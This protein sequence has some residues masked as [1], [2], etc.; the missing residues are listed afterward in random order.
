MAER[1]PGS[2]LGVQDM[3]RRKLLTRLLKKDGIDLPARRPLAEIMSGEGALSFSQERFWFLD[4]LYPASAV[5]HI[6]RAWRLKGRIDRH[7]LG[8]G[9]NAIVRRHEILRTAFPSVNEKPVATVTPELLIPL[10]VI[11]LRGLS[12]QQHSAETSRAL[13]ADAAAPFDLARGP[14]IRAKLIQVADTDH[15]LLVVLHQI[16]CDGWSMSLFL[17]ELE[18][19]YRA[20]VTSRKFDLPELPIHYGTYAYRQRQLFQSNVLQSQLTYWKER[21]C[22][23]A[24][25]GIALP[26]DRR[27]PNVQSF[28]GAR[29]PLA[30]PKALVRGLKKLSAEEGT[31]L[32]MTLM[33]AF[34]VLLW[35]YSSQDDIRV[36][37]PAANRSQTGTE[38]L[39]GPFVNTLVLRTDLSGSPTFREL[40][41]R[42][43]MHCNGA[44]AHQDLPFDQLVEELRLERDLGRNPLFDVMLAYQNYPTAELKL[45]GLQVEAL[46][47]AGSTAKFDLTLS[48]A[49]RDAELRGFFE[50]STDLFDRPTIARMARHLLTLLRRIAAHPEELIGDVALL[51]KREREQ[52]LVRWNRTTAIYPKDRCIHELF[53]AQAA[54]TPRATAV[55]CAGQTLTYRELNCRANQLA[56][57]LRKL[58][59]GAESR[60]GICVERSLEMVVGLL[61][62]LKAGGA[63]V[64]LDP[65]YP[66]ARTAFMLKDAGVEVLLTHKKLSTTRRL[67]AVSVQSLGRRP[68]VVCIDAEWTKIAREDSRQLSNKAGSNNLAYVIY[69]SGSTG[70]PKGVAIEHRN[71]VA[72]LC[73]AKRVFSAEQLAGVLAS[74]SICFD[75]SVFELFAPLCWGGKAIMVD[76]ALAL[77][78]LAGT[79]K[80]TLVNTVPSAIGE[81]LDLGALPPTVRTVNLAGEPLR[82]E[83]VERIYETDTVKQV[84]DLY[85]PSETTTYSTFTLRKKDG[86]ATIGRPIAN[87]K[88]YLLDGALRPVP[89][90]VAG[91]LFIGGAGVARGYLNRP[92]LTAEK[93]LRD[94]FARSAKARM[95]RTGD[96]ARYDV[97][98]NIEYLGRVDNQIKIRGYRIELGEVEAA[99]NRHPAIRES[100][101]VA[102]DMTA[103]DPNLSSNPKSDRQLVAYLVFNGSMFASGSELRNALCQTLP[104]YMIPA[105]FVPL[106]GLPL[107]PNGKVDRRA[108][109]YPD[110]GLSQSIHDYVASRTESEELIA[111]TWREILKLDR[112]GVHDNFFE[113]GGHSLLAA[114]VAGRLR[115]NF[116]VDLPLRR[117]FE[118]PTVALLGAEIDRLCRSTR[119]VNT[120]P[121]VAV[122]RDGA[123]RFPL[124]SGGCGFCTNW[125]PT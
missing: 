21:L 111:Q 27:R 124:R 109:P 52:I 87:T 10:P 40:L 45:P 116:N 38:N 55:E 96:L 23:S 90:G 99:L 28:R 79:G 35:R 54:R 43:R 105:V 94:P 32:F 66:P 60:V 7:A 57:Y 59:V 20:F 112:V 81:L 8:N 115:T 120:P 17:R 46:D 117:L 71:A 77:H 42:V 110:G 36:G 26:T 84:Y 47:L 24:A 121:I 97:D 34:N 73:W 41:R 39:M 19:F 78:S 70:E 12:R 103:D 98:G 14:L 74:T 123:F 93:F 102:R 61:G 85:G 56:R 118:L 125:M 75:L 101:V 29:L 80:V 89:I 64:P 9:I 13:N 16:V 92:Q 22:N 49:E 58:G 100:V 5:Y 104:E 76:N 6:S 25:V 15:V 44:L 119:G 51:S 2:A 62:I 3:A 18:T 114:R 95:Y 48:L 67:P 106:D 68:N 50:Y 82:T 63:Y 65:K 108:L 30:I 33:A 11:D 4:Q 1:Q 107:T 72:F 122:R 113:L 91:E 88:T 31:T 69:T 53:E 83:L 37:F 86:K